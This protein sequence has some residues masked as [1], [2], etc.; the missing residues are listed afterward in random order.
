METDTDQTAESPDSVDTDEQSAVERADSHFP[1]PSYREYQEEIL[2]EAARALYENDDINVVVIDAPTGIGKSGINIALGKTATG[3]AFYT[4]PQKKLRDQLQS[5]T[6]LEQY[7]VALKSRRDYS[8]DSAPS[9]YSDPNKSYSCDNCP[10]NV[11]SDLSCQDYGCPYWSDK[12]EAMNSTVATLTFSFLIVDGRVPV[13]T[14]DGVQISFD[15]RETLIIDEAHTLAEQVASLHAGFILNNRTIQTAPVHI[16]DTNANASADLPNY[17]EDAFPYKAFNK[18]I[19]NILSE[20]RTNDIDSLRATDIQ[21]ALLKLYKSLRAKISALDA[22]NLTESGE[23]VKSDFKSLIWK[24]ENVLNDLEEGRPWV[25]TGG[26]VD[27]GEYEVEMKP[28]YVDTFLSENVWDRADN[29]ILSTATL[30]YRN[31]PKKWLDRIGLDSSKAKVISKPMP[32]PAENR[33]VR[34]DHQIGKMS[35]GGV[36][37]HWPDITAKIEELARKHEGE[38]GL[39]HTVSYK[40]AERL[41]EAL[42]HLTMLHERDTPLTSKGLIDKWQRSDKQILL[43]PSMMEGVDLEGDLCRWQILLKVPYRSL[44]DPRVDYLLNEEKDWEWYNDL[45][46][47][48]IIQSVGRA[49]RSKDD[50]ATYYVFDTGFDRVMNGRMP[51]WFKDAIVE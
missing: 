19:Q 18:E 13:R 16:Y 35:S 1:F 25:F 45:A 22:V 6:D 4:T 29:I 8:C 37:E 23:E 39:I 5:D 2:H 27:E 24:V 12:E 31:N 14:M 20:H 33:P 47:R 30:P 28:V 7:H 21:P 9:R 48:D 34:L 51:Q 11:R 38:K 3:N 42:P 17:V 43:T 41:H 46:A 50:Y 44:G 10:V 40:R 36:N 49:V 32:F 26:V 15:D